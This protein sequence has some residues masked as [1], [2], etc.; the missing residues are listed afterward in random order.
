MS[1]PTP[2][3]KAALA[4]L[5]KEHAT[6]AGK[7]DRASGFRRRMLCGRAQ[8]LIRKSV[9]GARAQEDTL[10]EWDQQARPVRKGFFQT[11]FD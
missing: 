3:P 9:K 7:K 6:L 1:K 5:A 10:A 11:L 8:S 2:D 4:A